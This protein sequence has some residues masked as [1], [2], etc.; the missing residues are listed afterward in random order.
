MLSFRYK[1]LFK[2]WQHTCVTKGTLWTAYCDPA[3]D[4]HQLYYCSPGNIWPNLMIFHNACLPSTRNPA[5]TSPCVAETNLLYLLLKFRDIGKQLIVNSGLLH[6]LLHIITKPDG[7][8]DCLWEAKMLITVNVN[9]LSSSLTLGA[10]QAEVPQGWAHKRHHFWFT[11]LSVVLL[12]AEQNTGTLQ[13]V[14]A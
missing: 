12:L 2:H 3:L 4:L 13:L 1:S 10:T 11:W 7:I 6:C 8:H 9:Y 14:Y 5:H